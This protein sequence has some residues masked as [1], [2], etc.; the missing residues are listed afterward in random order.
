MKIYLAAAFDHADDINIV[1]AALEEQ[2]HVVTSSWLDEPPLGYNDEAY[3]RWE[4]RA[5][6]NEDI[7]DVRRSDAVA[8]FTFWPSTTGG[9]HWESGVALERSMTSGV[10]LIRVGPE[11]NIFSLLSTIEGYETVPEFLDAMGE[12]A[13]RSRFVVRPAL[14]YDFSAL[15]HEFSEA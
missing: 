4:R 5:R 12:V 8:F 7:M 10:R 13:P 11:E 6:A 1:R 2:G 15:E 3:R 9:R 14:E